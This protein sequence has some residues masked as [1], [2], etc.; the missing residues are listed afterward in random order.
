MEFFFIYIF[1]LIFVYGVCRLDGENFYIW[2]YS[3]YILIY[4]AVFWVYLSFVRFL[5]K[6]IKIAL[7]KMKSSLIHFARFVT[8]V[9]KTESKVDNVDEEK[10]DAEIVE[11]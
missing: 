5:L 3:F 4:V 11:E 8:S 1:H 10:S 7:K 2:P 9:K 6:T